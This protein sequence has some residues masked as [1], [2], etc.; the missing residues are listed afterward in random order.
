MAMLPQSARTAAAY[1]GGGIARGIQQKGKEVAQKGKEV[2]QAGSNVMVN[3]AKK[4]PM[5]NK[6][7]LAA[8]P[9]G[10][11]VG[12]FLE[13]IGGGMQQLG[14][15][16]QQLG[17]SVGTQGGMKKRDVGLAAA[18]LGMTGAFVGGMGANSG[19]H[20]LMGYQLSDPRTSVQSD[21]PRYGGNVM[22][23]DLQSSYIALNQ[24]GSP[25][26]MQMMR[27]TYD[28]KAAQERQHLLRAAM[29]GMMGGMQEGGEQ[30]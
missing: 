16:M 26:G 11:R 18:G 20:A 15:G 1:L 13:N 12:Q 23:A 24:L 10:G 17:A 5:G 28:V 7:A 3:T 19:I 14:G 27:Q 8:D 9:I 2:A 22:P 4:V 21:A 29:T 30:G 6:M 25:L